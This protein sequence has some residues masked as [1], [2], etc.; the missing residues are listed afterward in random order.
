MYS[1]VAASSNTYCYVA[2]PLLVV[3]DRG[4]GT[5]LQYPCEDHAEVSCPTISILPRPCLSTRFLLRTARFILRTSRWQEIWM[6]RQPPPDLILT[7]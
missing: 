2:L 1:N 6:C 3:V 7:L 4:R 5:L